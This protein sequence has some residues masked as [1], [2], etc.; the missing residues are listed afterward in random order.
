MTFSKWSASP[1]KLA[2]ALYTV[3]TFEDKVVKND[4][5]LCSIQY[6][7]YFRF[8]DEEKDC[9]RPQKTAPTLVLFVPN[10]VVLK[11]FLLSRTCYDVIEEQ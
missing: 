8:F 3:C 7:S 2:N 1:R 11:D 10:E 6:I 4:S 5:T 9:W